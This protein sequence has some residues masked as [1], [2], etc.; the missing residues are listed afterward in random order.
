MILQNI[1]FT[2]RILTELLNFWY[3]NNPNFKV[4]FLNVLNPELLPIECK[5]DNL[6]T[7]IIIQT[8][9]K[10][11][12]T[13]HEYNIFW[14]T[15]LRSCFDGIRPFTAFR[16]F[17]V[18]FHRLILCLHVEQG[19][20][21]FVVFTHKTDPVRFQLFH[22]LADLKILKEVMIKIISLFDY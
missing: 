11:I 21:N 22:L 4:Y 5:W 19:L 1:Y 16:F 7:K 18:A 2:L 9:Y 12:H 10:Q 15:F 8:N 13:K 3:S 17:M 14:V 6:G 20:F